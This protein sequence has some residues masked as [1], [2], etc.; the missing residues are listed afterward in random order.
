[1]PSPAPCLLVMRSQI[2]ARWPNRSRASDGIMGDAAHQARKSDHNLGNAID[3]T[4][5]PATGP[6]AGMLAEGFR[7]QMA[8]FP[9]G[10]IT[11]V[12]YNR[13][14]ASPRSN[15]QWRPYTGPNPHTSHVH[16]S[17][18]ATARNERRPWKL[19]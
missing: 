6:D 14:I 2:D 8:S 12:I 18:R 4:H 1:M 3:V 16:I 13:R 11:Y 15:W 5:S 7:R 9:A 17:I 19:G 10:R